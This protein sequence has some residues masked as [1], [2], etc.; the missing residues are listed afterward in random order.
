MTAPRRVLLVGDDHLALEGVARL[1]DEAEGW[2]IALENEDDPDAVV[3]DLDAGEAA[4]R[5]RSLAD[6]HA[7]LAIASD[8]L[9]SREALAFGA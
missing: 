1:L 8:A 4:D 7:V 6:R 9:S 3:V 5:L 2:S